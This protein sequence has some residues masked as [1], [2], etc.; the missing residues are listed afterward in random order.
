MSENRILSLNR[1][2][3]MAVAS[4]GICLALA[5]V[6]SLLKIFQMPQG[7]SVTP[8]SML[9]IILFALC[10][11]PAWG[12]SVAFLFSVLQ[13]AIG[14]YILSP[15]QVLLD[16]TLAFSALGVAGFFAA[17]AS[18]RIEET[19][20]LSRLRLIPFWKI[21]MATI[22]AMAGRLLFSFLSGIVFYSD[23]APEG[24]AVWLYSLI[25]NGSYLIP[26]AIITVSA[27]ITLVLTLN[28]RRN[29]LEKKDSMTLMDWLLA[30]GIAVVPVF[31]QIFLLVW[32]FD[33]KTKPVKKAWAQAVLIVI[34]IL[35]AVWFIASVIRNR[36][37]T[38]TFS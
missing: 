35:F 11:G 32:A 16:Y 38:L 26:E 28:V 21:V 6:L 19:N 29:R 30:F 34:S 2:K 15:A 13:L 14:A 25:Y 20:I 4:G 18:A 37:L 27:L 33:E 9:P 3:I 24:Q 7:G 31:G 17:K 22:I 8:A 23:Y 1:E 36:P 12:L 10:F 5:E